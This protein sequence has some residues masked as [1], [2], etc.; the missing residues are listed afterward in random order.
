MLGVEPEVQQSVVV[1]AG[2]HSNIAAASSVATAGSSAR[3]VLFTP[4]GQTAIATI[5][6]FYADFDFIDKHRVVGGRG[7]LSARETRD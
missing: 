5:P 7:W 6:G 2:H 4:E 3:Y 1:L